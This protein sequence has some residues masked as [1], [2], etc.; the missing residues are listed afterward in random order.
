M[1]S[2]AE[3]RADTLSQDSKRRYCQFGGI[4]EV[5]VKE[6]ARPWDIS[7]T[8]PPPRS[9]ATGRKMW[10]MRSG[11]TSPARP[12]VDPGLAPSNELAA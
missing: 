3:R 6:G 9:P 2:S 11:V 7:P 12:E 5:V 10:R 8:R 1:L 4:A